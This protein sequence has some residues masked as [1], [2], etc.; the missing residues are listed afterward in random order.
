V[1][2]VSLKLITSAPVVPND[3]KMTLAY[4]ITA[5]RGGYLV[6]PDI[7][8]LYDFPDRFTWGQL[9]TQMALGSM[10]DG[11]GTCAQRIFP[12]YVDGSFDHFSPV[13]PCTQNR[14]GTR[15]SCGTAPPIGP[16]RVGEPRDVVVCEVLAVAAAQDAYKAAHGTYFATSGDCANLPGYTP[17]PASGVSCN[18]SSA[19]GTSF[20]ITAIHVNAPAWTC[21]YTSTETPALDCF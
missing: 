10:A 8:E 12:A 18:L 3:P 9:Q 20:T 2:S 19:S 21:I 13:I 7:M 16:C 4:K 15:I 11:S 14:S 5:R 17:T 1:T 6:A